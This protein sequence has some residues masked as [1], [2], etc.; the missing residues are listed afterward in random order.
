M[1]V[2]VAMT[3]L[4]AMI[5]AADVIATV[6][7]IVTADHAKSVSQFLAKMMF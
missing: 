3:A 5:V 2:V 1:T 4:I 7:A 6:I